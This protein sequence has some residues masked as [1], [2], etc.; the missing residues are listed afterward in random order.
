MRS[1]LT[2]EKTNMRNLAELTV[3]VTPEPVRSKRRK[4]RR[5]LLVLWEFTSS[6][7][8]VPNPSTVFA[9]FCCT[10]L[11]P[12]TPPLSFAPMTTARATSNGL[13]DAIVKEH[14]DGQMQVELLGCES[15]AVQT[16]LG[17]E[18]TTNWSSRLLA[19]EE[20]SKS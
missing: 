2:A 12:P 5:L 18:G 8:P 14:P 4:V 3:P 1:W 20:L 11:S 9:W 7:F 10:K 16:P 17:P 19:V 6:S 13:V 15:T